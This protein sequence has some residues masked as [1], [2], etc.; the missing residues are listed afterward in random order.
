[1]TEFTKLLNIRCEIDK[2]CSNVEPKTT[3]ELQT[4][5]LNVSE[6]ISLHRKARS[7]LNK[8]RVCVSIC[9]SVCVSVCTYM[10]ACLY[11]V[12]QWLGLQIVLAVP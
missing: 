9:T 5:Y 8:D 6:G 10:C 4:Q 7:S 12:V 11:C 1:M 3:N 2:L